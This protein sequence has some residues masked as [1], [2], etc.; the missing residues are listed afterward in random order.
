MKV[1]IVGGVAGGATAA[2]RLRRLDEDAQ[3]VMIERSGY[4]SYANCGLPYYIG[5]AITDRAKLTLQTPQSFRN[6]FDIDVRVRQEV[7]SIDRRARTVTVR[8]L[9][10]GVEYIES[11]DKLD[12][13]P[14]RP[15]LDSAAAR[16]GR[17]APVHPAHRGGH[18]S[19]SRVH[20]ARAAAPRH[21]GGRRLHRPGDGREPARARSRGHRGAT[22]RARHADF[23]FRYGLPA[24]QPPARARRGAVAGSRC[25]RL[26][27]GGRVDTRPPS[28]TGASSR[29]T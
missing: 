17:R 5:G 11:Y 26:P 21:R 19:D 15:P 7:I 9:D 6:R 3:I 14:G 27:G 13:L 25:D 8:R 2:A 23:R 29:A 16:R 10:D 12:P 18:L 1:V 22:R 24:P 20:R 28:P 4:V